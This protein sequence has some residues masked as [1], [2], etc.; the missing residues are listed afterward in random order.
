[1]PTQAYVTTPL[2]GLGVAPRTCSHGG[3]PLL[4][5]IV[6]FDRA[7]AEG[8]NLTQTNLVT[9]SSFNGL[10]GLLWGYDLLP[11]PLQRHP[12]LSAS[13]FPQVYDARPLLDATQ[14]LYGTVREPRFPIAPGQH[15]L[16]ACKTRYQAGPCR[17]YGALA[18]AIA[19]NR[20]CNADLFLED[21]GTL[22]A[23]FHE[24]ERAEQEAAV[25]KRLID[26]VGKIGDNLSV[27]YETVFVGFRS[28]AVLAGEIGCVLTAAPYIHLA[29]DAV[30]RDDPQALLRLSLRQWEQSL[31]L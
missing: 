16:C 18:I 6:A 8:A 11:Q 2:I 29:Q 9:V 28:R 31:G 24:Q 17:L 21:R 15:V 14:A 25:L 23:G 10:Q 20:A 7:E 22:G 4:D 5:Q 13:D 12:C 1:M 19:A 3:S 26:A 30:P 27:R